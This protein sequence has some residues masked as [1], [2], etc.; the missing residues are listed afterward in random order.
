MFFVLVSY[1]YGVLRIHSGYLLRTLRPITANSDNQMSQSQSKVGRSAGKR[2][3]VTIS[4]AFASDWMKY[5][6]K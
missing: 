2:E 3:E 6:A 1:E 4:F 5:G